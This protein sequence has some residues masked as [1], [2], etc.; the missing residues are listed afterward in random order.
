MKKLTCFTIAI[1]LVVASQAQWS[2]TGNAGTNSATNY[3]GTSDNVAFKIK[4]NGT[5]RI[6][7]QNNGRVA[8]GT[9]AAGYAFDVKTGS[10]NT[11]SMYRIKGT[12][13]L[14]STNNS[15]LAVGNA[16]TLNMT[17]VGN[18]LVGEGAG[19]SITS[20]NNNTFVG[21]SV[22]GICTSNNNTVMGRSAAYTL[23]TGINNCYFGMNSGYNANT[24][25]SNVG[26]GAFTLYFNSGRSG[27]VAIG[28]SALYNNSQGSVQSYE[29]TQN[30]AVGNK[31]LLSN[32]SGFNNTAV[33]FQAMRNNITGHSNTAVG[34]VALSGCT[35]GF[36]NTVSGYSAFQSL[37]T[38][39]RNVSLGYFTGISITSGTNN[40]YVGTYAT[41]SF[42][43][44]T[45]S[46]A[47][48]YDAYVDASNKVR[49]GNTS[50]S[51]IGGQ[52]GW[53]NFSDARIKNNIV[54]N[55]PGL[56]FVNLLR[57]VTYH[58]DVKK[59]EA[60]LNKEINEEFEG[61]YDIEKIQF[62]GFLAQEVEA[63]ARQVNYDFSGVDNTGKIMGLRYSDFVAPLV[64]S[65]QELHTQNQELKNLVSEQQKQ[66]SELKNLVL[67]SLGN[68]S[69]LL[70]ESYLMQ[71][72]P[73]PFVNTT[74]IN[75]AI[76]NECS[77]AM[78]LIQ[79]GNGSDVKKITLTQKGR[80]MV[81]LDAANFASGQYFYSLLVDGKVVE[82]KSFTVSK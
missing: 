6:F 51:S 70:N 80:G 2:L 54:Q 68:E 34:L 78:L 46:S 21:R 62:T 45:N 47:I 72:E 26:I 5:T 65:V 48:G 17:G 9:T 33:G 28:D 30:T 13:I 60:L 39:S 27:L 76:P 74:N 41:G 67:K 16:G 69:G 38:G 37:T 29:A 73:N 8:L 18:T 19:T 44:I 22:G 1:L 40:S 12:R 82:K 53:T 7:V 10:I 32:G 57:P 61:K 66:I 52:V 49:I 3:V 56:E 25:S 71:N 20:A 77:N 42:S 81:I 23:S 55:V 11:D 4:T 31:A 43:S 50:V 14:Y 59:E 75:Y 64:K 58:Y 63:A 24:G 36:Y 15:N 79:S 35:S